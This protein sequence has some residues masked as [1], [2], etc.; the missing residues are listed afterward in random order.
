M[1]RTLKKKPP[2]IRATP[3]T[4][5]IA[6]GVEITGDL[7][8]AGGMRIDGHLRGDV[9]GRAGGADEPSLLVVSTRGSIEGSVRC[10][11]A[12]INGSVTGDLDIEHCLELQSE[13]RVTGTIRYRRLQMDV[14][15]M[16][17]GQLFNLE[18]ATPSG[19]VIELGS[20]KPAALAERR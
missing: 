7:V 3:L 12:V 1:F 4:T 17:Q 11:N 2:F 15:A 20:E 10:A 5:L 14:G 18:P 16:V 13:A 6:E 8:F 19:N 9:V